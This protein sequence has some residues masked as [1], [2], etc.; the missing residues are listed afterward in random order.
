ME[1]SG[2]LE[3]FGTVLGYGA[4]SQPG[5]VSDSG[6]SSEVGE[7]RVRGAEESEVSSLGKVVGGVGE[8]SEVTAG[9]TVVSGVDKVRPGV[10]KVWSEVFQEAISGLG[11]KV[12]GG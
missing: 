4:V 1:E 10:V 11:G 12:S 3:G 9:A 6:V 5:A 7:R 8:S 2:N